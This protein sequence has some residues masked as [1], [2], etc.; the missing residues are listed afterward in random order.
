MSEPDTNPLSDSV[1]GGSDVA[2]S[3]PPPAWDRPEQ[4]GPYHV[5]EL[6]GEGGM[7]EV[8][9][10][11]RTEP[12]HQV[13]AIKLIK[14]GMSSRPVVARFE[15]ERQTLA[16]MDHPGIARVLDAGTMPQSGRPY[17]VMDYVA[18]QPVTKFCDEQRLSIDQRLRLFLDICDAIAHAHTK[19]VLHR[20]I[21]PGNVLAFMQDGKPAIK[22][23]D[24]G[25]AKAL[26]ADASS[27]TATLHTMAGHAIG[28]YD[29]MSPEQL[30]GSPDI[31]TRS[32]VYSLGV[33]LYELLTGA[34]P[35]DHST[36]MG[37]VDAEIRRLIREVDPPRPSTRLSELGIDA[38]AVADRRQAR[39]EALAQRLRRE[40]EWIPLKAIRKERQRRYDSVGEL[41][42]DVRNYLEGKPL[43]AGPETRSYRVRKYVA[44]HRRSLLT[45]GL[46]SA[47][48]VG[49]TAFYVVSLRAE[50]SRTRAAL[51]Q[52][53]TQRAEAQGQ[54]ADAQAQRA[55][56]QRQAKVADDSS[57][58][59]ANIFRNAD[60]TKSLG[61]NVTVIQAMDAAV[62][63]LDDKSMTVEPMT[64]SMVRYV[65][66]TTYRTLGRYDEAVPQLEKARA[67]DL[68]HRLPSDPQVK[69]TLSDLA[70]VLTQ[71]GKID[72]AE[73]MFR[74]VQRIDEQYRPEDRASRA[75]TNLNLA[76]ILTERKQ[77]DE[78]ERLNQEAIAIRREILPPGDPDLIS[79]MNN[80]AML[81]WMQGRLDR[82][83][84]IVRE[85]L[86]MR[87]AALPA[88]HPHIAQSMMNLGV[89]LRDQKK[90]EAAEPL[91][92][93]AIQMRRVALPPEH[94]DLAVALDNLARN[95]HPMGQLDEAATL[96]QECLSIRTKS[97]LAGDPRIA[98]TMFRL[99]LVRID[100]G[101]PDE[102]ERLLREALA[103]QRAIRVTAAP[104]QLTIRTLAELL[105]K[106]GRNA[107]ADELLQQLNPSTQPST[108]PSTQP[109]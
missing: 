6:I 56:A 96:Y 88:G 94:P 44:R 50:Q 81:Y 27:T 91:L 75:I 97:L 93:E 24:F 66:G 37:A 34:K 46:V 54:R 102:A 23:I 107:Q 25:I 8:Y 69:V 67:L 101:Q 87:K 28:T 90:Y 71:Q 13:V 19:A 33:L 31:D 86:E 106:A 76:R 63:R 77:F 21:K 72:Q 40:L 43:L 60:P 65:I 104:T 20:D 26:G 15:S 42:A 95:L 109:R 49:S 17:F 48:L 14:L 58:F 4:V 9:R 35:F 64:E 108:A 103:I 39:V 5:L 41:A 32:D 73:A 22:V 16:L 62:A 100:Q 83:E 10:A 55:E 11:E 18:G 74:E 98:D 59:L 92:R 12:I 51:D 79:A 84:P 70:N 47:S 1:L 68:A 29:C 105:R 61:A 2:R 89:V 78:A 30:E 85:T 36:L 80:L 82:A 3:P 38:A 7:G 53:T 52:A 99:G 57:N 45:A